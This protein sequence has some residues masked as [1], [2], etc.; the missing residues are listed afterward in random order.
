MPS[1]IPRKRR[2]NLRLAAVL[3]AGYHLLDTFECLG[4]GRIGWIEHLDHQLCGGDV[5]N[6]AE[7]GDH[8]QEPQVAQAVREMQGDEYPVGWI[9]PAAHDYSW[10]SL[11][12]FCA[13]A[14]DTLN[15]DRF[16]LVVHDIGGPVGFELAAARPGRI[17]SLTI[18]NT[19]VDVTGWT[20]PGR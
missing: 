5:K 15:L 16:H 14:A 7:R 20:R 19:V 4:S 2:G 12:H 3:R 1:A 13:D 18:L 9:G 17:A 11:G 6:G 8:V 10:T